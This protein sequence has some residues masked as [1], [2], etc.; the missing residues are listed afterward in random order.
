[1]IFIMIVT[2]TVKGNA[3]ARVGKEVLIPG[4]VE[5]PFRNK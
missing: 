2:V 5:Y 4:L 3:S 1:M